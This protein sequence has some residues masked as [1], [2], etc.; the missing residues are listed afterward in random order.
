[1]TRFRQQDKAFLRRGPLKIIRDFNS[2]ERLF[3]DLME[4]PLEDIGR[5]AADPQAFNGMPEHLEEMIEAST[6]LVASPVFE[7]PENDAL[8]QRLRA[9][10]YL[11]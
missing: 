7:P 10:G 9:L 11:N 2:G 8:K 3:F 5:A 1:M 4:N 6:R